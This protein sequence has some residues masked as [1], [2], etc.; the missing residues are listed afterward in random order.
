VIILPQSQVGG[1]CRCSFRPVST[2][3]FRQD[4]RGEKAADGDQAGD[5][6]L[7]WDH[8]FALRSSI[9]CRASFCLRVTYG[10]NELR[11]VSCEA[12]SRNTQPVRFN[13]LR[14][15]LPSCAGRC[16]TGAA[17]TSRQKRTSYARTGIRLG[18]AK[19][20]PHCRTGKALRERLPTRCLRP[21]YDVLN[22][23]RRL[24]QAV[25]RG[26]TSGADRG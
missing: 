15:K 24:L 9:H 7:M 17:G 23:S 25:G 8:T 4:E 1:G 10:R 19:V 16:S 5:E 26:V 3:R 18:R 21:G 22:Q 11:R 13:R 2:A 20:Q 14:V 12:R 6:R